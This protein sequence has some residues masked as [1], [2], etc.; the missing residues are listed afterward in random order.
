[1]MTVIILLKRMR[2]PGSQVVEKKSKAAMKSEPSETGA[3]DWGRGKER[4]MV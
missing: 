1:M 3:G 2:C 4:E